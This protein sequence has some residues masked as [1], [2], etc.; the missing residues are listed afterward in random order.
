MNHNRVGRQSHL[1]RPF[2]E[3]IMRQFR[4]ASCLLLV[5]SGLLIGAWHY[6][7]VPW[8]KCG[9]SKTTTQLTELSCPAVSDELRQETLRQAQFHLDRVHDQSRRLVDDH[10]KELAEFFGAAKKRMPAFADDL[11]G[12]GSKWRLATDTLPFFGTRGAHARYVAERFNQQLFTPAD[13]ERSITEVITF[14]LREIDGLEGAMLVALRQDLSHFSQEGR[15]DGL[16]TD[17]LQAFLRDVHAEGALATWPAL[18]DD[19]VQ[20]LVSTLVAEAIVHF[21][22]HLR[23]SAAI[24]GGSAAASEVSFGT[25][26]VIGLAVDQ[27]ISWAWTK[28]TDPK[29]GLINRLKDRLDELH[30]A[31]IDGTVCSPGLRHTLLTELD[32]RDQVRRTALANVLC[33][34]NI[35]R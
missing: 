5:L 24:L 16:R 22:N 6:A 27:A 17:N 28:I 12:W 33:R 18:R 35:A 1:P 32:R 9:E 21:A 10:L 23:V 25:S 19:M 15:L 7:Q 13:I 29:A 14:L 11:V 4:N 2:E 34:Q 31:L 26:F 20:M 3:A 8:L 30:T